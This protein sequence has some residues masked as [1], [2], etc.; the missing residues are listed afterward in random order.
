[1]AG[2]LPTIEGD[3]ARYPFDRPSTTFGAGAYLSRI[4]HGWAVAAVIFMTFALTIGITQYSFGVFVTELEGDLGWNRAQLN[5]TLTLFAVGG[6]LAPLV[7]RLIDRHGTRPVMIASFALLA[8]SNLARPFVNELWQFYALS[9]V[10]FAAVPGTIMLPAGKLIGIW[11]PEARGRAMGFASMGANVGGATFAALTAALIGP[12]GWRGT[13]AVYGLLFALAIP[14]VALIVREDG[15]QPRAPGAAAFS[16]AGMTTRRALR[17]RAFY[18]L[19]V[20]LTLAQLTYLSVL[21][22]IVP[23]LEDVG[24]DRGTAAAG[25]GAMAIFGAIGKVSFG[26]LTEHVPSRFVLM[27]SLGL[28]ALGLGILVLAGDSGIVW[29]FVPIFG[30]GFGALGALMTLLVQET[31]GVREFATIFGLVNFFT[32]GASIVGPPLVGASFEATGGYGAAFTVI[33]TLFVVAAALLVFAA[34]PPTR[35]VAAEP[36]AAG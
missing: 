16:E 21:T 18:V 26:W 8:V 17:A 10:Q 3:L 11:F 5:G 1:M 23:H 30:L 9:L 34:P 4:H 33:A 25:L 32:Q 22:Q 36:V 6:L 20:S 19:V 28:Q 31:F 15:R 27:L 12:L 7:G 14:I 24:F 2:S 35:A 13:Y 29:S